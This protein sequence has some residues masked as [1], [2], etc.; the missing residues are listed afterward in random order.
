MKILIELYDREPIFNYLATV[1]Y[2]PEKVYFVGGKRTVSPRCKAKTEKF[3]QLMGIGSE[4]VTEPLNRP[5]FRISEP[6]LKA[7]SALKNPRATTA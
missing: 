5:I 7:L 3:A 2:K 1:F 6:S 4:F